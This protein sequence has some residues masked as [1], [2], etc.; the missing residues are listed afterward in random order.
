M[1]PL[2]ATEET[3]QTCTDT[4]AQRPGTSAS[5]RASSLRRAV[6]D[7]GGNC[8]G[9]VQINRECAKVGLDLSRERKDKGYSGAWP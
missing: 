1:S 8:S 2:H 4:W 5:D 7:V 6:L 9:T 3:K